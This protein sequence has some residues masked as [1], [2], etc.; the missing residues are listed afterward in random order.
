MFQLS[1][2]IGGASTHPPKHCYDLPILYRCSVRR[3]MFGGEA[4]YSIIPPPSGTSLC[5]VPRGGATI[6]AVLS[7]AWRRHHLELAAVQWFVAAS[8][9][10]DFHNS[11]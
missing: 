11:P 7:T 3:R 5:S 8:S 1:K 9:N 6:Y 4:Q 10:G 2:T